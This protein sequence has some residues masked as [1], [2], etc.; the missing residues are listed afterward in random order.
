MQCVFAKGKTNEQN[1]SA[2]VSK[3]SYVLNIENAS[4]YFEPGDAIFISDG[5][6]ENTEY[7][8]SCNRATQTEA[9]CASALKQDRAEGALVW[10]PG[11]AFFWRRTR[12]FPV[13]RNLN[14]GV[15]AR[16]SGGGVV[17]LTRI[18]ESF[19]TELLKFENLRLAQIHEF[20]GWMEE[21][22]RGGLDRFTFCDEEGGVYEV[23]LISSRIVQNE[24]ARNAVDLELE[25]ERIQEGIYTG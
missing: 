4:S 21:A 7:L 6:G 9:E 1:L 18:R 25:L 16:R 12:A 5:N 3:G 24:K 2:P 23:C 22:I 13:E 8:G 15:E 19:F 17:F 14:T 10:K 11:S 20:L